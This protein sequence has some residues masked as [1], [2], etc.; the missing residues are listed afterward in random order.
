MAN[1]DGVL[2]ISRT[3]LRAQQA[4]LTVASQNIANAQTEGYSRARVRLAPT[5]LVTLPEG[6]VGTGV[7]ILDI[8]RVRDKLLD[9]SHR[10]EAMGAA[11]ADARHAELTRLEPVMA[12]P[13]DTGLG[14]ALDAFAGAWADLSTDPTSVPARQMVVQRGRQVAQWLNDADARIVGMQRDVLAQVTTGVER[15]NALFRQVAALN[16]QIVAL[17]AGGQTANTLRDE[18]DRAVDEIATL[19]GVETHEQG[20]GSLSLVVG[21]QTM[22]DAT[23]ATQFSA[24]TLIGG[25]LQ[26]TIGA[27]GEPV[28]IRGGRIAGWQRV[29][30]TDLPGVRGEL[31][32]IATGLVTTV[33]R[34]HRTGWTAAGQALG[35]TGATYDPAGPAALRGSRVDF[36][37]SPAGT[38]PGVAPTVLARD[39][40]LSDDVVADVNVVAAGRAGWDGTAPVAQPGDNAIALALAALRSSSLMPDDTHPGVTDPPATIAASV[41]GGRSAGEAWRAAATGVGLAVADA[42]AQRSASEAL[43]QQTDERRKAVSGVSVDEELVAITQAQQAY[44]AAARVLSIA[45]ELTRDLLAIA[46]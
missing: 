27:S 34:W 41:L 35:K 23:R 16:G 33:N 15:A 21:G 20:D 30:N 39:I 38:A 5:S 28:A 40:R 11:A 8:A 10:R 1:F 4:A 43:S 13:S 2:S 7:A 17:E 9:A 26:L 37:Q 32:K 6:I 29:H 14:A 31:D 22:V 3:A 45:A 12:E 19:T 44:Q 46:R 42:D 24:P 25:S 18:R 36:F